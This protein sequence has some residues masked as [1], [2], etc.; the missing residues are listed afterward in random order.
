V[1]TVFTGAAKVARLLVPVNVEHV[2]Q[3]EV[4]MP[5]C[6][7]ALLEL[8]VRTAAALIVPLVTGGAAVRP[9]VEVVTKALAVP[10]DKEALLPDTLVT[11]RVDAL[12]DKVIKGLDVAAVQTAITVTDWQEPAVL[13]GDEVPVKI[14]MSSSSEDS[15]LASRSLVAAERDVFVAPSKPNDIQSYQRT[16]F[17]NLI[18]DSGQ[19]LTA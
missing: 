16:I 6:S 15:F 12:T 19:Y 18:P 1:L 14:I 10:P 8:V 5:G 3:S 2:P 9:K 11:G 7:A 17:Q 4:V 13:L